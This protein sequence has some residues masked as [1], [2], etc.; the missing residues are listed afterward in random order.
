MKSRAAQHVCYYSI[1]CAPHTPR[2]A[3]ITEVIYHDGGGGGGGG[4]GEGGGEEGGE[5][6]TSLNICIYM[7]RL[8]AL[9]VPVFLLLLLLLLP[10][11]G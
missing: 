6:G 3:A 11:R 2:Y 1:C 10:A 9:L 5:E 8:S 7:F 4:G